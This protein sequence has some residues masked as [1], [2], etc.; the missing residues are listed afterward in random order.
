MAIEAYVE[1]LERKILS[2]D[3]N[4]KCHRYLTEDDQKALDDLRNYDNIN[5]K[6]GDKGSG[7]GQGGLC[8]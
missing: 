2:H 4:V 7:H 8:K 3:L 1:A 5:V 6:Q